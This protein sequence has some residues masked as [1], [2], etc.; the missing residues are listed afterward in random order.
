MKAPKRWDTTPEPESSKERIV[1]TLKLLPILLLSACAQVSVVDNPG[2]SIDTSP[3]NWSNLSSVQLVES[4]DKARALAFNSGNINALSRAAAMYRVVYLR[5]PENAAIQESY[6][7]NLFMR[8]LIRSEVASSDLI[9]LF[10]SMN[11]LV[12]ASFNPPSYIDFLVAEEDNRPFDERLDL[13]QKSLRE[14]PYSGG[15]WFALS[16]LYEEMENP[17]MATAAAKRAVELEQ[18]SEEFIYQFGDSINDIIESSSCSYD[19]TELLKS[20]VRLYAK[21]SKMRPDQL[22]YDNTALQYHRLGLLPLALQN[23]ISAYELDKN[24]WTVEH[25]IELLINLGR[26]S[27]AEDIL[28]QSGQ[29][30]DTY[31][32]EYHAMVTV[33]MDG[34]RQPLA[35]YFEE[36]S[37]QDN[38]LWVARWHWIKRLQ[39][40]EI[41]KPDFSVLKG[42]TPWESRIGEYLYSESS[43][44]ELIDEAVTG[45]E[46]TEAYF[47]TAYKK[48]LQGDSEN[49]LEK[50]NLVTKQNARRYYEYMWAPIIKSSLSS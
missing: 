48:W 14:Q 40:E 16:E 24:Q 32:H 23:A 25:Y 9:T 6:Y 43:G 15:L 7:Q 42:D 5:H 41:S 27:Q 47:Y 19:E 10:D 11:P 46:K 39:G 35:N 31:P 49:A 20:S 2:T 13:L 3:G 34:D 50:L 37:H 26:Y 21:S 28:L 38:A 8:D 44:N 17:W 30:I 29:L 18:E 22:N 36:R 33:A 1:R 12:K 4:A 45:C